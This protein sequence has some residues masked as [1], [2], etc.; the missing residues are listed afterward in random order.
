MGY[1]SHFE[2]T[3][4]KNPI[5]DTETLFSKLEDISGGYTFDDEGRGEDCYK[6]YDYKKDMQQ[7]SILYPDTIFKVHREGEESGD[8]ED[9][10]YKNGKLIH[11]ETLNA[12]L[13]QPDISKF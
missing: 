12:D 2:I 8:I 6:W 1:Y 10:Y 4:P 7:L 5:T 9:T 3:Q 13:P 11:T